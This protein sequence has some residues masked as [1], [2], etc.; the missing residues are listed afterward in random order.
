A[1]KIRARVEAGLR[2]PGGGVTVSIGAAMLG[3]GEDWPAWLARSDAALYRAKHAGRN[4][5][6]LASAGP[7][8]G[9]AG[10]RRKAGY[11]G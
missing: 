5:V 9:A 1:E 10:D 4:R 2:S 7:A 8:I 6:E 3:E 11:G